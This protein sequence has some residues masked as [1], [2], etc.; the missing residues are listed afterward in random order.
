MPERRTACDHVATKSDNELETVWPPHVKYRH[1]ADDN[2]DDCEPPYDNRF[3]T[4]PFLIMYL[5]MARLQ[6]G[7]IYLSINN[8][9]VWNGMLLFV[10]AFSH[11]C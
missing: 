11:Y 3:P 7:T 9:D 8:N 1:N 6:I 10:E 5:T 4:Y 2:N